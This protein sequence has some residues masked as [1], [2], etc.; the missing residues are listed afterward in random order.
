MELI[1]PKKGAKAIGVHY[2]IIM[3]KCAMPS[4]TATRL[5]LTVRQRF[6]ERTDIDLVAAGHY[7]QKCLQL[8]VGDRADLLADLS[9][10]P[11]LSAI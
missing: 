2:I 10:K 4:L 6:V 3:I 11:A 5:K 7:A 8:C 1:K 9:H